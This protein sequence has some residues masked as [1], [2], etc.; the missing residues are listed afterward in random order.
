MSRPN[1]NRRQEAARRR[2]Q[3]IR[4]QILAIDHIASGTISRRTKRC[5]KPGCRC[6]KD[7][8][9][10]HG[11]YVEWTRLEG[12]RLRTTIVD[13]RLAPLLTRAIQQQRRLHRLRRAWE[14]ATVQ[15]LQATIDASPDQ[16]RR[17]IRRN[18]VGECGM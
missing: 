14:R 11:P 15:A 16:P 2:I 10:R 13:P 18:R 4:A 12:G 3:A 8:A 7:T 1:A 9:A 17:S 5:G 6:A